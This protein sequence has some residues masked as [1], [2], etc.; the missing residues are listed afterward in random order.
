MGDGWVPYGLPQLPLVVQL[1]LQAARA[2]LRGVRLLLQ[3]PN[4]PPHRL[5]RAAPGHCSGRRRAGG[6]TE[7]GE[8]GCRAPAAA[9]AL[10]S[11]RPPRPDRSAQRRHPQRPRTSPEVAVSQAA[12]ANRRRVR[13]RRGRAKRA[14][15]GARR[16]PREFANPREMLR[17]LAAAGLVKTVGALRHTW[18]AGHGRVA[19]RRARGF[20]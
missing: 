13:E 1:A 8:A 9:A 6:L 14:G 17:M 10:R 20:T 11:A 16:G 4:F 18:R 7:V 12:Q 5:Q 2:L 19:G 3:A 15:R